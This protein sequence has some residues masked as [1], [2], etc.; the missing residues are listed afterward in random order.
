MTFQDPDN[1]RRPDEYIDKAGERMGWAPIVLVVAFVA[2]L[3]FL[4]L[5]T[6]RQADQPTVSERGEV[7]NVKPGAPSVPAPAPP[8]PQ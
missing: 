1:P 4:L 3:A 7:P 2:V 8:A 6:P 5:G